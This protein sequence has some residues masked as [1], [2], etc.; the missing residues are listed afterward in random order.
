[1]NKRLEAL[2]RRLASA[3]K[4]SA[5]EKRLKAEIKTLKKRSA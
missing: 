1:M 4:G 5:E 2:E 3:P